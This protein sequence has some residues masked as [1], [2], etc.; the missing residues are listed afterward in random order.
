MNKVV[1]INKNE[2]FASGEAFCLNCNHEWTAIAP[3]GTIQ[4]ECTNCKT[5]KGLFRFPFH[6]SEGEVYRQCSCGN[7]LFYLTPQ[8]H[9][10]PN[11]G[12]YQLYE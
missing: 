4:L 11:C 8:G 2:K 12:N 1:S 9:L 7:S 6:V 10:C 3:V 5:M